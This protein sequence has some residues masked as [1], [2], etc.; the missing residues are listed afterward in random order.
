M[1]IRHLRRAGLAAAAVLALVPAAPAAAGGS[2]FFRLPS[3]NIGCAYVDRDLRCDVLRTSNTLPKPPRSCD[4]DYGDAFS[5]HPT[6]RVTLV[7]H[8]DTAV[9]PSAPVLAYGRTWKHA[10][11]TCTSSAAGLRCRNLSG[12]GFFLSRSKQTVV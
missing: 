2:V 7:C 10:G 3:H 11:F 9:D 4:L 8:G 1:T 12:H 5:M 6:G